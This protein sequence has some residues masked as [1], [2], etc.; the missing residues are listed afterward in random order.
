MK[1]IANILTD[2]PYDKG[3]L[4]NVVRDIDCLEPEIPTLIIGWD[5]TK[6]LYPDASIIEW[7]V[8]DNVYWTYGKYERRDKFETNVAKFQDLAFKKFVESIGYVF[9]DAMSSGP[10]KFSSFIMSIKDETV[11]TIYVSYDMMYIYYEG[12]N[13]VIGLSLR[14]CDYIDETY[15][16]QIFSAIYN[17]KSV[18]V[19]KNNGEISKDVRFRTRGMAYILPYIYSS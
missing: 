10:G 5:K 19:L 4:Y 14:D 12:K 6:E 2:E 1:H 17:N 15:K 9:Y 16:K 3:E 8:T 18:N 7:K 13:K 11:K